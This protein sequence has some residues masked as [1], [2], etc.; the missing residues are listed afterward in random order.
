MPVVL[1]SAERALA[2]SASLEDQGF[3]VVAIRPPTVPDGTARL[4]IA[5]STAH[6]DEDVVRL[7]DA[8]TKFQE[9]AS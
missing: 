9:I 5:F 6:R 4:R 8:I 7:A 3:L 1:G 2:A